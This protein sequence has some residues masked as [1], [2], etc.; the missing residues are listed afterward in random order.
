MTWGPTLLQS[1]TALQQRYQQQGWRLPIW[2]QL[3]DADSAQVRTR[4]QQMLQLASPGVGF[5]LGDAWP[6]FD[7]PPDSS[8]IKHKGQLLG[9]EAQWIVINGLH[10]IDWDLLAASSGCLRAGGLWLFISAP[11]AE[12]TQQPNPA[13][14]RLLSYPYQATLQASHFQQFW[15]AQQ[16]CTLL[17]SHIEPALDS[18]APCGWMIDWSDRWS[19]WQT[20]ALCADLPSL[21]ETPSLVSQPQ[22]ELTELSELSEQPELAE[23]S[24]LP[25]LA[26]LRPIPAPYAS[27]QQQQAVAAILKVVSGHRR[28]PLLLT[29][30]RGRGK[31]A[32]LGIAAAQLQQ[33]GK[34]KLIITAPQPAAAAVALSH[35]HV[36]LAAQAPELSSTLQF[37][38]IDRLLQ[39]TPKA[40]LVLVDEAAAIPLPQLQQ[41]VER[42]SRLVFAT[43]EHGYEGTGRSFRLKFQPHLQ[44]HCPGWQHLQLDTPIRYAIGDPLEQHIFRS[45]LLDIEQQPP[46]YDPQ[47]PCHLQ[48]YSH[49]ELQQHPRLFAQLFHL[50]SLAHYQTDITDL[51]AMLDNPALHIMSWQQGEQ[52][53]GCAV[54]SHEGEFTPE[55]TA[56]IYQG[57]RRVQGHLLAQSLAFHLAEPAL[58]SLPIARIQRIVIHPSLQGTGLG[59]RFLSALEQ[60]SVEQGYALIG[61]SFG[62][63]PA[64]LRFWL[65]AGFHAVKLSQRP[66]QASGAPSVLLLKSCQSRWQP[67]VAALQQWFCSQLS[68]Q[69]ADSQRELNPR[70]VLQLCQPITRLLRSTVE[71]PITQ[72]PPLQPNH[73]QQL[74]LFSQGQRPYELV[75]TLLVDWFDREFA[76]IAPD[77]AVLLVR[78]LWQKWSWSAIVQANPNTSKVMILRQ[79]Q[80]AVAATLQKV[81]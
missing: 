49:H 68:L 29:A 80:Q 48:C 28:R 75:D 61:T 58:A 53:L 34:T 36:M 5:W 63:T 19:R 79:L 76:Q 27:L 77:L 65:R 67:A 69:L 7:L 20:T 35:A 43:T 26:N 10:G 32:A 41:L 71:P 30:H 1:F 74:L 62:A 64:L 33:Q 72:R 8:L 12:F 46:S 45:F 15:L 21:A 42:Y 56:L 81:Q 9:C 14:Q 18:H 54:I 55:L 2:W 13:A 60:R 40:D 52:L 23:L 73:Q 44:Q 16:V 17:P 24:H 47:R 37:W 38:P 3:S 4:L 39:Q 66:D 31:S 6:E 50:L 25:D 70:L 78:K 51:W 59:Q 57:Q 11:T 22:P